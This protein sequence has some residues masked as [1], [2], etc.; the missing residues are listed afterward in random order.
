MTEAESIFVNLVDNAKYRDH[1]GLTKQ[2]IKMKSQFILEN[3]EAFE[4]KLIEI[5]KHGY[6]N[7]ASSSSSEL[8]EEPTPT[9]ETNN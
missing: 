7:G 2:V 1:K 6:E 8:E 9:P 3:L 5:I 4:E